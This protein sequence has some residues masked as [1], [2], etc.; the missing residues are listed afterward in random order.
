VIR[1]FSRDTALAQ[2]LDRRLEAIGSPS[3]V[4]VGERAQEF[5]ESEGIRVFWQVSSEGSFALVH[6][7]RY[8]RGKRDTI[9][10]DMIV[11]HD[12]TERS[13][14]LP[15]VGPH[16]DA[17]SE[18]LSVIS[19]CERLPAHSVCLAC[20]QPDTKETDEL[21]QYLA[22]L[23]HL[24]TEIEA[25]VLS[26]TETAAIADLSERLRLTV[27]QRHELEN[28]AAGFRVRNPQQSI[29]SILEGADQGSGLR[30]HTKTRDAIFQSLSRKLAV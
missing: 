21:A 20:G 13:F 2:A 16:P 15:S 8:G 9:Y 12:F 25:S 23:D 14:E 5:P 10:P 19:L 6:V 18:A 30:R 28:R 4:G 29:L 3:V 27:S 24:L 26:E 7:L 17:L 11:P 1:L 22:L